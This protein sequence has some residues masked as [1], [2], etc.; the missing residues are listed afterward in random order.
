MFKILPKKESWNLCC[1][2]FIWELQSET[3][4]SASALTSVP[5]L[6]ERTFYFESTTTYL[7]T[8]YLP[9][10]ND[11][12]ILHPA[13]RW[14]R[15]LKSHHRELLWIA[16]Y[17]LQKTW[18]VSSSWQSNRTPILCK[19]ST[20]HHLPLSKCWM[21]MVWI[22]NHLLGKTCSETPP[23]E[24]AEHGGRHSASPLEATHRMLQ[25][26]TQSDQ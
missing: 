24:D 25:T 12:N 6:A 3:S 13:P 9:K 21:K 18:I 16:T 10:P 2:L 8:Q 14:C 5:K 19:M 15:W 26:R 23:N 4:G 20:T 17:S 7:V 11:A 1:I 22:C